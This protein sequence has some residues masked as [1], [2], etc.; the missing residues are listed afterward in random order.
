[1]TA[2]PRHRRERG[3]LVPTSLLVAALLGACA[4]RGE[5][6]I[7]TTWQDRETIDRPMGGTIVLGITDDSDTQRYF[8]TRLTKALAARGVQAVPASRV[9]PHDRKLERK[10]LEEALRDSDYDS[11]LITLLV[12]RHVDSQYVPGMWTTTATPGYWSYYDWAWGTVYHPGYEVD[13][14]QLTIETHLYDTKS[15]KLVWMAVSEVSEPAGIDNAVGLFSS[16]IAERLT[17]EVGS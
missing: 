6:K 4:M 15:A 12:S 2:R 5:M 9:L 7:T 11:I 13:S 16:M 14:E 3:P 1:M 10:Q 17:R 8:E